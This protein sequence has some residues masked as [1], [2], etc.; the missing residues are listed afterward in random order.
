VKARLW[1]GRLQ[2]RGCLNMYFRKE[3]ESAPVEVSP[4]GDTAEE[5]RLQEAAST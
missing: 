5:L 2:L 1:R 3:E 4:G